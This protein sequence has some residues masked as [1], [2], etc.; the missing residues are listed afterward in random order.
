MAAAAEPTGTLDGVV[1][2]AGGG[3]GLAPLGLQTVEDFERVLLLNATGTFLTAKHSI[4]LLVESKGSFVGMSS[5]AG[6]TTHRYFTGYTA[7]KGALEQVVRNAADEYGALGVRFNAVRPGFI[8]TEIME[9]IS[10]DGRT[11]ASYM[12]NT[13]LGDVG[14]P[15]DVANVV[16]FLLGP[17]SKWVTGQIL[18]IDGGNSLRSGPDY[19]EVVVM[20]HG[21]GRS[22]GRRRADGRDRR[23]RR[24]ARG[25]VLGDAARRRRSRGH[26]A[27]TRPEP[28]PRSADEAWNEWDVRGV[29][30]FR[31]IHYFLPRFRDI[32]ERD[33]PAVV[34][35]LDADGVLRFNPL[36]AVPEQ[37]SGGR[38]DG[39][40]RYESLTGRRPMVEAASPRPRPPRRASPCTAGSRC[41]GSSPATRAA[42]VPH[43]IGVVTDDGN[44][45][46]ADLVVDAGG[47]RSALPAWLDADRRPPGRGAGGLRLRVLRPPLPVRRR[48]HAAR[49]R[50][51]AAARTTRCRRSR[52]RPTTAPG[53]WASSPA[54]ATPRRGGTRR[55]H[56]E[57][58]RPSLPTGRA[59]DRG[60]ADHRRRGHGQDRGPSARLRRRRSSR[61]PPASSRSAT[62]GRA[63]T[64]RSAGVHHR[65]D[66]RGGV[67]RPRPRARPR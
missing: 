6:A 15:E 34:A 54:H 2:N 58:S 64:R 19:G 38:R 30:Q 10:R 23:R 59:L 43:V 63:R 5:F 13:P 44:E 37:V 60:R 12:E 53:A 33:L 7:G 22:P 17:E 39:D 57:R 29:N 40:E 28:P 24:R 8:T 21:P 32:V 61:W 25:P 18:N 49:L 48:V 56:V 36:E 1:A 65:V 66:P 27:R 14:A 67:A 20:M 45:Q 31:M 16:R 50:A 42:G 35:A 52:C 46:R 9:N 4:P 47:R 26:G 41:A 3:G 62:R 11:Y 55:R 51:A